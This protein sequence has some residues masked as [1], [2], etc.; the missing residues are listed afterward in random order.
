MDFEDFGAKTT[1]KVRIGTIFAGKVALGAIFGPVLE[2]E[3][4]WNLSIVKSMANV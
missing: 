2:G 3:G 1:R 4:G